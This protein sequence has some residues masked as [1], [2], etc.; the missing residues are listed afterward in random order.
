MHCVSVWHRDCI[1]RVLSSF[2]SHCCVLHEWQV[3]GVVTMQARLVLLTSSAVIGV[4]MRMFGIRKG[5]LGCLSIISATR[6]F[7]RLACT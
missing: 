6:R 3:V 1:R 4:D 2:S 5:I 7:C